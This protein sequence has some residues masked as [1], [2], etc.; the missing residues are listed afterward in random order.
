MPNNIGVVTAYSASLLDDAIEKRLTSRPFFQRRLHL[1]Q[2]TERAVHRHDPPGV[3]VP[4]DLRRGGQRRPFVEPDVEG[5][6]W[7]ASSVFLRSSTFVQG[8]ETILTRK[9]PRYEDFEE[10]DRSV[11]LNYFVLVRDRVRPRQ[12]YQGRCP[13]QI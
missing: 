9:I 6:L 2:R 4:G 13:A 11:F 10:D 8:A 1:E 5:C 7:M 3:S 12:R